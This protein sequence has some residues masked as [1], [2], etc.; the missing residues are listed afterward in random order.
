MNVIFG[1]AFTIVARN[2]ENK[3]EENK[4]FRRFKYLKY[5]IVENVCVNI[6]AIKIH[7][8]NWYFPFQFILFD[9]RE[10]IVEWVYASL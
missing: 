1:S 5:N 10:P 7:Y 6:V 9:T 4:Y 3:I 2:F 8:R